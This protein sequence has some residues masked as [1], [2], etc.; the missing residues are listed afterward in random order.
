LDFDEIDLLVVETI[1]RV[2]LTEA[3]G[4]LEMLHP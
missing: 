1:D 3:F 2:F 4:R